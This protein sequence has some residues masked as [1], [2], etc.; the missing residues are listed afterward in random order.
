MLIFESK[1]YWALEKYPNLKESCRC[2]GCEDLL[3]WMFEI[4]LFINAKFD[5]L[6]VGEEYTCSQADKLCSDFQVIWSLYA[7]FFEW[8]TKLI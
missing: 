7:W 1:L 6:I 3:K 2:R 5:F 4:S 8:E